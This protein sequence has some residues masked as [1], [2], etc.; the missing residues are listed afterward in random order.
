MN[1]KPGSDRR[2][3]R[4]ASTV[5]GLGV[6][7]VLAVAV[8]A[9]GHPVFSNDA[10]GFPNPQ[11]STASPYPAGSRPTLN[12]YVPFEQEGVIVNG[13]ENTTVDVRVTVPAGWTDPVCGA[14]STSVGN[15]QVGTVVSGW[16]C[17]IESVNAHQ[18]LHWSGP[19]IGPPP[20]TFADSAQFFAFQVTVPSPV[21]QTSYG[22]VGGPEGFYV[23][24]RYADGVT[25]L[26]RTPN[27]TREGEVANGIVR[28]VAGTPTP[29][30]ARATTPGAAPPKATPASS[31]AP[32]RQQGGG[33]SAL[34]PS[35]RPSPIDSST[36]TGAPPGA[37]QGGSV[38]MPT[39][40][41][42]GL[43]PQPSVAV[44]QLTQQRDAAASQGFRWK[45][46]VAAVLVASV[47]V[48]AVI[49]V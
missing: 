9:F 32:P 42:P 26:W 17:V 24:Q 12:M 5:I 33:G 44:E 36:G 6:T 2:W 31:P 49:A 45:I 40:S 41:S 7:M 20:Q 29:S 46:L 48:G 18:V 16:A 19:Q 27:S 13:A 25:S 3:R 1:S 15:R 35:A 23:E 4:R 21:S 28:T 34:S 38:P 8:P 37:T 11:G 10:P 30:P 22:A 14:V 39:G 43:D 47:V